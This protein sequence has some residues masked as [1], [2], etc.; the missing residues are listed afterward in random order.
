MKKEEIVKYLANLYCVAASDCEVAPDEKQAIAGIARAFQAGYFE[1]KEAAEMSQSEG[2]QNDVSDRLSDRIRNL[3]DLIHVA[4]CN[5][6]L[7]SDEKKAI[8]DYAAH[9]S[10][11]QKQ[12]D[13]IQREAK[14][15]HNDSP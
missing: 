7:E 12:L 6:L 10:I 2:L 4:Y 15:R 1:L 14:R 5:G 3:E 9:L 13:M 8:V 11:D